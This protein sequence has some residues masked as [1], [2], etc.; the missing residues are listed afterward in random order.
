MNKPILFI[1]IVAAFMSCNSAQ[2]KI[3]V[4]QYPVTQ[5][6]DVIDVYFEHEVADPY[7]WLENDTSKATAQWVAAQNEVTFGYLDQIPFREAIKERLTEI[8]DYPKI[9]APFKK[10]PFYYVFKNDGLQNQSVAYIKS[11]L[12]DEGRVILDPNKLSDDGTV[13][14]AS[15]A[16][17]EDGKYLAYAISRGGS[18]WR[19][20]YVKDIET[21]EMLDDHIL[22]AKFSGITWYKEGFFYTRYPAPAQGDALKGVNENN[23]IYYHKIG[24]SQKEDNL[25]YEDPT[26]PQWGFGVDVTEDEKYMIIY[27]TE[28]T[29]GNGL[30][31]QELGVPGAKVHKM[32]TSFNKD[33]SVLD[34]INGKFLVST[35]D[36]ASKYRIMAV[37]PKNYAL[38]NWTEFVPEKD[39][40]IRGV[41]FLS[42]KMIISYMKDARSQIEIFDINGEFLYQLD[43]DAVGSISG[44]GGKSDFTETFY[45]VT[46]FTEPSTVYKYDVLNNKSEL[47][48]T[49]QMDFDPSLYETK[50]VFYESK[51]GTKVP[52]FIVH[53][54]G[55]ELNGNNPTLLYGY[56]GFN[57][58]LTPSFSIARLIWLENNGVFALANL[59][60]GGE[61]GED[62]HKAGTKMQKQNVF[63]DFI[64]AAEYL[65]AQKYT[66]PSKITIQGGSNGGLLV[67]AVT[68]QRPDLF[69]VALPAVGV[70]DM[71]RY[72]KFTIGRYWATDYGTSEDSEEMFKYLINYSPL[73]SVRTDV[74]YPAVM[75]TTADHDDRVVPAHSFKYIAALQNAYPKGKNPVLIRIEA[76]A[77]HGAG[78]PTSKV[79]EEY[80][81][82]YSFAFYNM[83]VAPKYK[84]KE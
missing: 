79:I 80:A 70:M 60:G 24:T 72:H 45:T 77:G 5:K 28:S 11:N 41:N 42:D 20:I 9:S 63:D 26:H 84:V 52:M 78:K 8:W 68:N 16:P 39:G 43:N 81:D 36:G 55:L 67:G 71:L 56:G 38:D 82:L 10:G 31:F 15:F 61:Y 23:K 73:H 54:K 13:S 75:V 30:Y 40:V 18:D 19:E 76:K 7:R 17:S 66:N 53:K 50:Q 34:H 44:F 46:S 83:G 1:L 25:V 57:V 37:D 3:D 59:R 2:K 14:L 47:Y 21:G 65:V 69:A 29:S 27:V 12:E 35:N 33:Y 51:D 4:P 49:A 64:T 22:W 6:E 74:E 48:Q 58:S 62:W 32:I